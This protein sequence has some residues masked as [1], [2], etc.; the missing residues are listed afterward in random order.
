MAS[1]GHLLVGMAGG[2]AY[3]PRDASAK[4]LV[5]TCWLFACISEF[6]DIDVIGFRFGV[7]YEAP[8]GHRGATHSIAFAVLMGV[9]ALSVA[10]LLKQPAARLATAVFVLT[11]SHALLDTLTDGG[12]GCAL[13]WPVTDTRFFAPLR[14]LPVAPIGAGMLSW[15]GARVVIIE[16]CAFSPFLVYA[17]LPRRPRR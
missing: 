4:A 9:L 2:R 10:R 14:P 15:R 17:L 12:L 11:L 7:A 13:G 1:V 16:L 5:V 3:L 6:P 8:F